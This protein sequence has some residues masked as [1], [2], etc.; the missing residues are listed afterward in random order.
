MNVKSRIVGRDGARIGTGSYSIDQ[1][2]SLSEVSVGSS[3]VSAD[4]AGGDVRSPIAVV[5]LFTELDGV[6]AVG[7]A[8]DGGLVMLLLLGTFDDDGGTGESEGRGKGRARRS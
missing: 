6:L 5:S 2:E 7:S 1:G 8:D 4:S 3:L